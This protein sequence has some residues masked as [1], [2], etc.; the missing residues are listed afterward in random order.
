MNGKQANRNH[1]KN[2][3]DASQRM[4][5]AAYEAVRVSRTDMG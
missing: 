4:G 3:V 1:C 5:K 2:V